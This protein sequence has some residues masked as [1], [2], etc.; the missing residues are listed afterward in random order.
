MRG[1]VRI[2]TGLVCVAHAAGQAGLWMGA[3]LATVW[4][5]VFALVARHVGAFQAPDPGILLPLEPPIV[6]LALATIGLFAARLGHRPGTAPA[7]AGLLLNT[8]AFVLAL[9]LLGGW[10]R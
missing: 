9:A 6:G 2:S 10:V 8:E 7:L 3:V 1:A 5:V 4:T